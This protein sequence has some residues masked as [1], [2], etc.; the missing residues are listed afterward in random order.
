MTITPFLRPYPV[1]VSFYF[2]IARETT[3]IR[4][5]PPRRECYGLF[6]PAIPPQHAK[7]CSQ[8]DQRIPQRSRAHMLHAYELKV[9]TQ[10]GYHTGARCINYCLTSL[11]C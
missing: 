5:T 7:L 3:K 1:H 11:D 9:E 6:S 10:N 8:S 4:N 2:R